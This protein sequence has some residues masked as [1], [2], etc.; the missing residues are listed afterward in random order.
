MEQYKEF[1]KSK[2]K[3]SGNDSDTQN[4]TIQYDPDKIAPQIYN[5]KSTQAV[6]K[7]YD[8]PI[9]SIPDNL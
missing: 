9:L 5:S 8:G 2:R 1:A 7:I 6:Y 3:L 4:R